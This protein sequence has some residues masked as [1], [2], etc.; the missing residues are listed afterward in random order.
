MVFWHAYLPSGES[1]FILAPRFGFARHNTL[2]S[3][4]LPYPAAPPAGSIATSGSR[5]SITPAEA[6]DRS[7]DTVEDGSM[8]TTLPAGTTV[9]V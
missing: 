7:R 1:A 4:P 8:S 2:M 6:I 9:S 5:R 3:Q